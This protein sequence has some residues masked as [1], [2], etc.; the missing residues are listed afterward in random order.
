YREIVYLIEILFIIILVAPGF[1]QKEITLDDIY[2]DRKFDIKRLNGFQW[3]PTG[4]SF[5]W[6]EK[7]ALTQK[8]DLW[9]YTL[10][11]GEKSIFIKSDE[12]DFPDET[13]RE[14]RFTIPNYLWSPTGGQI[15]FPQ[16]TRFQLYDLKTK[17]SRSLVADN[18][19]KRDAQFS[20]DGKK[21]MYLKQDNIFVLDLATGQ[22]TQITTQGQ[23]HLWVGR[24][25]WVY[26]EEFGIRTG[27]CWSPDGRYIA[28]FQVDA[29]AE[30][31]FPIVDFVPPHNTVEKMRYPKPG[32]PN[33]IVKIAAV[34]LATLRTVWF[35]LGT[36]TDLYIP[37]IKWTPNSQQLIIY[38]LNRDQNQLELLAGEL[39]QGQTHVLLTEKADF[40][41]LS[42]H[43]DL[44]F[45]NDSPH[46]FWLS[47][48]DHWN[49]IYLFQRD[50][51]L[52]R[53]I[54]RGEWE[55]K[56]IFYVDEKQKQIYFTANR[57]TPL[58]T[59]L[60]RI[61]FD[62]KGLTL[63]SA[64]N[65]SHTIQ[66]APD[67]QYYLDYASNANQPTEVHVYQR[68][69]K[70][71]RLFEAS[72]P[73]IFNEYDFPTKEFLT[74][75]TDDSVTLNA[76]II[77]P[78]KPEAG[79]KYPVLITCYGG[80]GS[81]IVQNNW[82]GGDLWHRMLAQQG[83]II[84]GIDNRGTGGRGAKFEKQVYRRLGDFEVQ[85]HIQAVK[86][87]RTLPEVAAD[88]IGIW[89]WSYGGYTTAICLLK[90]QAYFKLGIAV[91][92]VTDWLN[93][94]T[95]Y[96]ERYMDQPVDNPEGYKTSSTLTYADQLTGKLLLVH[97][98][99]DDNVHLANTLQLAHA[100][101]KEGKVF[102]L[103]VYPRKA[104]GIE[105]VHRQLFEMLTRYVLNQL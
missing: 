28:Y 59:H 45:L 91:A 76:F 50:G 69:G 87:L 81:Q 49:H 57:E 4:G 85:D 38:R 66:F 96:T 99:A 82:G 35:D 12:I 97:G 34:E 94:D 75:T 3:N 74:F 30:P 40:G 13:R 22:E 104:H 48:R 65:F 10:P 21:L 2:V 41:W 56:K 100:L 29:R 27:F 43:D 24:F 64:K 62:G 70:F 9:Q 16:K 44:I 61:Q 47:E 92:P 67:G 101:Q 80:P 17:T 54:T 89:G 71:L 19:G 93:Y 98:A 52:V 42:L 11:S 73:A 7:D 102:D 83:V 51:K 6:L 5:T 33:A 53:Q 103:M 88:R 1:G 72:R 23:E 39:T 77:R 68:P 31:E 14:K 46:F 26:E 20:P 84:F 63:L 55:V 32:D 79:K 60:Y 95:I 105:A 15:L 78:P 18:T 58:E 36:E 25:D 86:Y 90:G 8:H 37:R